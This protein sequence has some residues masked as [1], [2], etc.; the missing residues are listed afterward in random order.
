[1]VGDLHYA[2]RQYDWLVEVAADFDLVVLAGDHLDLSSFA[3][4]EAQ[5]PVVLAY[6]EKLAERTRVVAASGNHDLTARDDNGEKAALWILAARSA[7]VL[8]D[9]DSADVDGIRV[10]VSPWWDGPAGQAAVD[11]LLAASAP[12]DDRPWVWVYHGPPSDSPLSWGGQRSFGDPE[13]TAWIHRHHPALVL[14]G[15]VHQAPFIPDGSW[16]DRIDGTVV[17][18][19]GRMPGDRPA[20]VIIDFEERSAWWWSY[21]GEG[22]IS[23]DEDRDDQAVPVS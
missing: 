11:G 8:T 19:A 3:P 17:L 16:H 13:L 22:E 18:N 5:I 20:H 4:V 21:E 12:P 15:H 9:W 23:L 1:M 14:T 6:L 10:T 7:G 2:L